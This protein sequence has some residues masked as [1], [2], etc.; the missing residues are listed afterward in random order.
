[1]IRKAKI[2]DVPDLTRLSAVLGYPITEEKLAISLKRLLNDEG[3]T[4][5]VFEENEKV[6]GFIEAERYESIYSEEKMYNVLGL[7]VDLDRQDSGIGGELLDALEIAAKENAIS[8]IRLNSGEQR[9]LAHEF[10]EKHGYT[11]NHTQ[12]RFIKSL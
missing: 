6:I 12:K 10:Y 3:H 4:V 2:S 8:A 5:L 1:M 7:V 11:S 9:D